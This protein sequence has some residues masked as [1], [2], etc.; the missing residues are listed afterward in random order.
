MTCLGPHVSS[1]KV[2]IAQAELREGVDGAGR[3]FDWRLP[4][5]GGELRL[6]ATSGTPLPRGRVRSSRNTLKENLPMSRTNR[7]DFL[8]TSALAGVGFFI[9]GRN[10]ALGQ[11]SNSPN[12][13]I[14]VAS[15]G[16]GGKGDSD[17][18][19]AAQFANLVAICDT[20]QKTLAR[21]AEHFP[22]AKKYQDFRRMLEEMGKQIDAVTVSIAD[23]CHAVAAM[24]A[25]KMGKHVY[26]QKPLTHSVWEARML[27]QAANDFKVCTQM[28][29]QGS[30]EDGLRRAVE[31]IQDGIIGPVKE[32]H[33]W[34]N[35]PIWPQ[36]PQ[37]TKRPPEEP[38]PP[39]L[40]W[41]VW[42]GPAPY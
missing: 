3:S 36:S 11:E 7:R 8:K 41:D 39:T 27:Q 9:A 24:M 12:E 6:L 4:S 38:V 30:A 32:V 10:L 33:V 25:M 28:G 5:E 29:N 23:H 16:V 40:A 31:I 17:S 1:Q 42:L 18:S 21:K 34:T 13:R 14:N 20:D 19:Q 26:S 22:K 35:R 37:I 15:I 2:R